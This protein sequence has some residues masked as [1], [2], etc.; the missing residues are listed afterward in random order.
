MKKLLAAVT[1][2]ALLVSVI[3]IASAT[4]TVL[5]ITWDCKL[6]RLS[7]DQGPFVYFDPRAVVRWYGKKLTYKTLYWSSKDTRLSQAGQRYGTATANRTGWNSSKLDVAHKF[8][9]YENETEYKKIS[10][11]VTSN[12][13]KKSS[14]T[15][16]WDGPVANGW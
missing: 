12:S 2:I 13:G 16:I 7:D 14:K 10:L 15:C 6:M 4:S 11:T 1:L 5:K 9:Y 8:Y 3:P